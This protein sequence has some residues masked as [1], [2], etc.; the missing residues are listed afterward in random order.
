MLTS[1]NLIHTAAQTSENVKTIPTFRSY[2]DRRFGQARPA[3]C[4]ALAPVLAQRRLLQQ[5]HAGELL[6]T[7]AFTWNGSMFFKGRDGF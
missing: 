3:G 1:R 2:R 7:H 4:C 5:P 6:C